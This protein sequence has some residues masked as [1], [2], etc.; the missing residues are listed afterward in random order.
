MTKREGKSNPR[1]AEGNK[2]TYEKIKRK[3]KAVTT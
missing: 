2:H 3:C 1:K